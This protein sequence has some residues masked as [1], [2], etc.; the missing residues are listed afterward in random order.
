M[1][2]N[3]SKFGANSNNSPCTVVNHSRQLCRD[4]L[5]FVP[6]KFHY[7]LSYHEQRLCLEENLY[8]A[9]KKKSLSQKQLPGPNVH[10]T[11]FLPSAVKGDL[12]LGKVHIFGIFYKVILQISHNNIMLSR[13]EQTAQ[14]LGWTFDLQGGI[15]TSKFIRSWWQ[16]HVI[17]LNKLSSVQKCCHMEKIAPESCRAWTRGYVDCTVLLST[18][19]G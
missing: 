8:C 15:W 2:E 6:N 10:R 7:C 16:P 12:N 4:F 11:L 17:V 9:H 5:C 13:L 1:N 14:F 19:Q 18:N 3:I